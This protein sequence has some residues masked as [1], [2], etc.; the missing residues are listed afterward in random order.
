MDNPSFSEFLSHHVS[1]PVQKLAID[2][3]FTCPNRDGRVGRGGCSY[4]N[5]YS[6]SPQYCDPHLSVTEQI[7]RGKNFFSH[8]AKSNTHYLAYFQSYSN[9]Y[10]S[11]ERLRQLYEEALSVQDVE[12]LVIATRPDCVEIDVL[13]YLAALNK[14][15]F[16]HIELG[17]ESTYDDVLK[18]INRGHDFACAQRTIRAIAERGL[19]IGVHLI[20]GLPTVTQDRDVEQADRINEL[21]V[22]VLKLHQLQIL[23]GTVMAQDFIH[24][25]ADYSLMTA[26][27]YAQLVARFLKRLKSSVALERYVSESPSKL[28]IAPC[29]GIKPQK[30]EMLVNK[31]LTEIC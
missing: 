6:Y 19:T 23:R 3:G 7:Q 30:V 5:N 11:L 13:D 29:W 8:K 12:G 28:L 27:G 2:A 17:V 24:H 1:G 26:E 15:A 9:T 20:L 16:V 14:E 25:Q 21:P 18:R 31:Y 4:C 10:A 22:D